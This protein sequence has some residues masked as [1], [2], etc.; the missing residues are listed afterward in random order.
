MAAHVKAE[1]CAEFDLIQMGDLFPAWL[2]G[3][4]HKVAFGFAP[5]QCVDDFFQRIHGCDV[6]LLGGDV[7]VRPCWARQKKPGG[8]RA[9]LNLVLAA[10]GENKLWA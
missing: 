4:K 8:F 9:G 7:V 1:S 10:E 5:H 6:R 2:S 3:L